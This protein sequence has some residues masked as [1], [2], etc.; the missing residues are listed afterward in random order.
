MNEQTKYYCQEIHSQSTNN[1]AKVITQLV[2]NI[3]A[4]PKLSKKFKS[5]FPMGPNFPMHIPKATENATNPRTLDPSTISDFISHNVISSNIVSTVVIGLVSWWMLAVCSSL[6][7]ILPGCISI[8]QNIPC[9][10]AIDVTIPVKEQST[11]STYG[12]KYRQEIA[13]PFKINPKTTPP[14]TEAIVN[15]CFK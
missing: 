9:K 1:H 6:L 2:I 4:S 8:T 13:H 5:G 14:A 12:G 10:T 3:T 15:I 11:F 7:I